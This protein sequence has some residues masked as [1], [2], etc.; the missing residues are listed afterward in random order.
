MQICNGLKEYKSINNKK[1]NTNI[2]YLRMAMKAKTWL[3][4]YVITLG[5]LRGLTL[6]SSH[7]LQKNR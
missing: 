4:T 7:S 2:L 1:K 6:N 5:R 3:E